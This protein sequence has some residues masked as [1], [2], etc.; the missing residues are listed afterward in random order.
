MVIP[1]HVFD[2]CTACLRSFS[3]ATRMSA[4]FL[5]SASD[6]MAATPSCTGGFSTAVWGNTREALLAGSAQHDGLDRTGHGGLALSLQPERSVALLGGAHVERLAVGKSLRLA[7]IDCSA[8]AVGGAVAGDRA[9]LGSFY[10]LRSRRLHHR[11]RR[12]LHGLLG[13]RRG[14]FGGFGRLLV[15]VVELGLLLFPFRVEVGDRVVP[16]AREFVKE[17]A[18]L[19]SGRR[20]GG[21]RRRRLRRRRDRRCWGWWRLRWRRLCGRR[22]SRGRGHR[23]P[24]REHSAR[25]S[26]NQ[27][28]REGGPNHSGS[29]RNGGCRHRCFAIVEASCHGRPVLAILA[30]HEPRLSGYRLARNRQKLGGKLGVKKSRFSPRPALRLRRSAADFGA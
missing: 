9:L 29:R 22:H 6:I 20:Q 4:A 26:G 15:K 17:P 2:S 8:C 24:L 14:V 12:I 16:P 28:C 5:R 18:L 27:T 10:Y 30:S 19:G 23:L 1:G 25:C 3:A 21:A 13:R 7:G 11:V